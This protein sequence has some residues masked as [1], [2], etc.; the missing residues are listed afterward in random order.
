MTSITPGL[1][2]TPASRIPVKK[3]KR[4]RPSRRVEVRLTNR[5]VVEK[6]LVL[7]DNLVATA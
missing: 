2:S 4:R 7:R 5:Q 3:R 6:R 1:P